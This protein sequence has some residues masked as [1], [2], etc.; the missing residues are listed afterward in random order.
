MKSKKNWFAKW[1][2][3]NPKD[4]AE[5][6][7][8]EYGEDLP[9]D[10][11][12]HL[13]STSV[14]PQTG[15]SGDAMGAKI[16]SGRTSSGRDEGTS[17]RHQAEDG[18]RKAHETGSADEQ[19][20][21]DPASGAGGAHPGLGINRVPD[22]QAA[23]TGEDEAKTKTEP[24]ASKSAPAKPRDRSPKTR[25][26]FVVSMLNIRFWLRLVGIFLVLDLMLLVSVA[27][28]IVIYAEQT[29]APIA[30]QLDSEVGSDPAFWDAF[31]Y[32]D[33][34]VQ[35][36]EGDP[37]G[38][39]P[40]EEAE[41]FL[42]RSLIQGFRNVHW[43]TQPDLSWWMRVE[44]LAYI[45]EVPTQEPEGGYYRIALELGS[46][47]SVM[48]AVFIVLLLTQAAYVV[49]SIS[50]GARM[51]RG[52]MGPIVELADKAQRLSVG[53]GH[54]PY[55]PDEMEAF[56]GKLEGINAARL[57][58]RIEVDA[59]QDDLKAVA[60]AINSMLE[61][62]HA[63]YRAQARFVSDASHELRTPIAAIQGYANLLD[64]WG[65]NDPQAL[66]ESIDAIKDE[67]SSMKELIEQLL[68]LARGD[69]H[70]M[71]LQRE[72]L[73]IAQVA[74]AVLRESQMMDQGHDYA[75]NIQS[76][77]ALVD[78]GLTKQALRILVDN[79]M[80][81]TPVG[82]RIHLSVY[83][84]DGQ[85]WLVVQDEGIGIRPEAVPRI[86]DRFYRADE[87]RA[88]ATGGTGLGLSIAKWI[89]ERHGGSMHVLSREGIGTR[90]SIS[91]PLHRS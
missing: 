88:R 19:T 14:R 42:P 1:L 45:A 9:T 61:R 66:Q 64:R 83:K 18:S 62:I 85:A 12:E 4:S 7:R 11:S 80:K 68:F 26:R 84:Q 20:R 41:S 44:S 13:G 67:A 89:V 82:G 30:A 29:L 33:L 59:A 39:A 16:P 74:E 51:I 31:V 25:R 86:F 47:L 56:A 21:S 17:K 35:L 57:D 8:S 28:G 48:R 55:T 38:F 65:K 75:S 70:T 69:N 60:S 2:G 36:V 54:G 91:L 24:H 6:G 49:T 77:V 76:V 3:R 46:L 37:Q 23:A 72:E 52:T 63:S 22:H 81:Y 5:T 10:R 71:P 27:V 73:D 90:M 50:A 53:T 40:P 15:Q 34:S 79:A 43:D 58:T 87:S 78:P 32:T